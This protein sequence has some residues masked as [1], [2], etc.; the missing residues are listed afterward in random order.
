MSTVYSTSMGKPVIIDCDPGHD[1]AIALLLASQSAEIDL[2]GVT[3]VAG[4][5]TLSKTTYNAQRIL[6]VANQLR[7][8]IASGM[9]EPIVRDF[10]GGGKTHGESGLE[11]PELPEPDTSTIDQHAVD[12]I[13]QTLCNFD[14]SVYLAPTG[15]LTN[16]AM[17]LKRYP[18]VKDSIKQIVLMGGS[19]SMGNFTPS[20][21][22]NIYSDPEAASIVFD[23]GVPITMVGLDV[24]RQ[25]KFTPEDF[26]RIRNIDNRVS[27]IVADILEFYLEAYKDR[28]GWNAVNIH[29]ATVIAEIIQQGIVKTEKMSVCIETSGEHTTGRTVCDKWGVTNKEPNIHVGTGINGDEFKDLIFESIKSY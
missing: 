13:G 2:L 7:T 1:D 26:D 29:D 8:P 5:Q 21:E 17:V 15:P 22:F 9:C 25:V 14:D 6:T 24:T 19:I 3:T 11:G 20:A 28:Y 12:Y 27:T 16:I 4:N 18:D 23:S 10:V